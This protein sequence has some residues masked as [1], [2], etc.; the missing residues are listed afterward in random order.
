MR[1]FPGWEVPL[2]VCK[3]WIAYRFDS[4]KRSS[5]YRVIAAVHQI[6]ICQYMFV[7]NGFIRSERWVN[8]RGLL[9]GNGSPFSTFFHP[10]CTPSKRYRC[11]MHKCIPYAKIIVLP[12]VEPWWFMNPSECINAFPTKH[13]Y[14]FQ[15]LALLFYAD[16]PKWSL[17]G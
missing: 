4:A 1:G 13:L 14:K 8:I 2:C 12:F 3:F 7:G 15:F 17:S 10:T 16:N 11:G 9:D 5:G 6:G